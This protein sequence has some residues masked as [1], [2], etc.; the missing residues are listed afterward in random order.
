LFWADGEEEGAMAETKGERKVHTVM[1]EYAEGKLRSSSGQKVTSRKQA[2]A[3]AL[4]EA[5][6]AGAKIPKQVKRNRER[7]GNPGPK[8]G[9]LSGND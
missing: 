3:I 6:A 9:L 7:E 4:S 8:R 1:G 2:V 5:R